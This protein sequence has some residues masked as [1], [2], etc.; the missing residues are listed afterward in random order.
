MRHPIADVLEAE[1]YLFE[2]FQAVRL[3]ERISPGREPVGRYVNP[4]SEVVRFG[5]HA[6]IAF[7]ASQ[8]QSLEKRPGRA[9]LMR[10]NFMGLT[11]PL[12]LMPLYYSE[13]LLDRIRTKDT[14]LRDFLDLFNHRFISLFYQ[15]WEKY[16]FAIAYERD[17]RDRFSHHLLDLIG[18][19]SP[20]LENRQQV[21]DDSLMF[22]GGLLALHPRSATTL[23]QLLEDYFDVPVGIEQ[24]VGAWYA[25][26]TESQ[27]NLGAGSGYSEQLGFGAVV[28]NEIWDQQS[29]VRIRLGP[30]TLE[31]YRGFLPGGDAHDQLR[32]LTRF[33][34]GSEF[35]IEV[36]L[37][38]RRQEVPR[39]ELVAQQEGGWQLG[40]STWVKSAPFTRDPGD[41][42][43]ELSA[44]S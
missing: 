25:M 32:A 43:L 28:G 13:L 9:P 8:I 35:D 21:P 33:F 4:S 29:R 1:P 37:V 24:F 40:W 36:Q 20:G 14:G 5:A 10:V 15:A 18:M 19:G 2:F 42:I 6:G 39:C 44:M 30:L 31:R 17:E 22:Y 16:R 7:P 23:E 38:L 41:T 3:L 26:D 34:C 12:G 11:G 27:C